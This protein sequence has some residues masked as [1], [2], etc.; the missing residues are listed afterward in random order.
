M[1]LHQDPMALTAT[2][3]RTQFSRRYLQPFLYSPS[4]SPSTDVPRNG[5]L[6]K[7]RQLLLRQVQIKTRLPALG[8]NDN[9]LPLRRP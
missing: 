5:R 7:P 3:R 2:L 9:L 6:V 8:G 1:F 4:S